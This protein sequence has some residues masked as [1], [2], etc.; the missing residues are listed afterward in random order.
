MIAFFLILIGGGIIH[1][2]W[3]TKDEKDPPLVWWQNILVRLVGT[4]IGGSLIW[5]SLYAIA[6]NF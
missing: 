6:E 1:E 3:K 4:I 5:F 2:C